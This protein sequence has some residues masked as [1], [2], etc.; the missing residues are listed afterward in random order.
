MT[1]SL[2]QIRNHAALFCIATVLALSVSATSNAATFSSGQ[3]KAFAMA[4]TSINQLAAKW[5]SQIQAAENEDQAAEMLKQAD[6][7]MRQVIEN[8]DGIGIEDYRNILEAAQTD[9]ALK[10]EIETLLK[11]VAPN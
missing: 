4:A 5:Q 7:E 3:L 9:A 1:L 11:D 6:A 2:K 8:A 10:T